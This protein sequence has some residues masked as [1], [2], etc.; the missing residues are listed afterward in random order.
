[1]APKLYLKKAVT[2]RTLCKTS[3]L[4]PQDPTGLFE[5]KWAMWIPDG[6]QTLT[7]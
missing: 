3:I 4:N 7:F 5:N 1:M 2:Y 6:L